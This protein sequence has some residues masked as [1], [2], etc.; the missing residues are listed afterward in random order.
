MTAEGGRAALFDRRHHLELTEAHLPGIGSAPGGPLAMQNVR[1]LQPRAGHR[2]RAGLR[3]SVSSRPR[4]RAGRAGWSRCGSW[5]WR[6]GCN[7]PWCR[8]WRDRAAPG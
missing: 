5:C 4:A 3:L 1:D 2:R 8:A 7:G 6:R